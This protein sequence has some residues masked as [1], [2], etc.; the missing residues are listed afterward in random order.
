MQQAPEPPHTLPTERP[1]LP[2]APPPAGT[3]GLAGGASPPY[4]LAV[5]GLGYVGLPL[6]R[7]ACRAGLVVAGLDRSAE[8]SA[9]LAAG[10]S[11]IDDVSD[12]DV[13]AMLATG[14]TPTT[15]PDVLAR[16]Q[17]IVICVPTPL[18]DGG[19][20]DL[21]AVT[22]AAN[23]V[24]G[25]LRPGQLVVLESTSWPGTTEEGVLPLLERGSG[26][27]AGADFHLAFSPERID[28]GN[29]THTLR[30]TPKVVG[31]L[32]PACT[33]SAEAL[34]ARLCDTVVRARGPKE[35]ELSKLLENTY[36]SVNIALVNEL[37][38]VCHQ[39]DIDLWD[40]IDCA[41]TKP[42]GFAAFRPGPG[43][44][45]HCIPVDPSYLTHRV[46]S[47][48]GRPLRL[49]ETAHEINTDMPTQ[50][51]RRVQDLLSADGVTLAG[52]TVLL[53][54][55]TYKPDVS[56]QRETPARPLAEQLRAR[57]ATVRIHDP[58]VATL[59]LD[60]GSLTCEPDLAGAVAAADV[61]VLLQ[62]HRRY[63]LDQV[64]L[65]ARRVFDTSGT[66]APGPT[67][68]RL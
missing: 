50:V 41:A 38:Q 59:Q 21:G 22:D 45:G 20:P 66:L 37:A 2:P 7:E 56:D 14:F 24:A 65:S 55:V 15:D 34:Y 1:H 62:P 29:R 43:V 42:F 49:V 48:L 54:G 40:V 28:P 35:A 44:G 12:G 52:A 61:V 9:T 18:D 68:T 26:L 5:I 16:A 46:R 6:A 27:R 36:R 8:V 57:G 23:V 31:G 19:A 67:V 17:A 3:P 53:L 47:R 13:A 51:A 30:N 25:Q 32:T 58:H 39:L 63:D 64:A 11:H 4:D 10:R 60:T 33:D